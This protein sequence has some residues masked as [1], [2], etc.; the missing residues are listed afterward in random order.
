MK[1]TLLIFSFLSAFFI[2]AQKLEF[3]V[4]YDKD[5]L[6][7]KYKGDVVDGKANGNGEAYDAGDKKRRSMKEAGKTISLMEKERSLITQP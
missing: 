2:N 3:R 7:V 6:L 5:S 1:N 4:L